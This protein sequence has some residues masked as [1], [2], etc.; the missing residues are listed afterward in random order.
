MGRPKRV[1]VGGQIYHVLNRS[2]AGVRVFATRRDYRQFENVLIEAHEIVPMRTLTYC[3]MPNHWHLVL[4]PFEDND[5]VRFLTWMTLTHTQRW[6]ALH[7]TV[8]RGHLY[9]GRYKSFIVQSD[10][11]LLTVCRYVEQNPLRAG[12]VERAE[13]W[14]WGALWRRE[15]SH[16]RSADF[17]SRW[18]VDLPESWTEEVNRKQSAG[19]LTR[20]RSCIHRGQPFGSEDWTRRTAERLGLSST[21]VRRG[22][23]LGRCK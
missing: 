21:F 16:P 17:L 14:E 20:I 15:A 11:H 7:R 10:R 12:L 18:P 22:R 3:V 13:Q 2:N 9:Q 23:P 8:G 6:H 19:E 4:W 1:A 5:L